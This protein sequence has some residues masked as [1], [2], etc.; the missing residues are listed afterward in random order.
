MEYDH[1][2]RLLLTLAALAALCTPASP[3]GSVVGPGQPLLCGQQIPT[4][5]QIGVSGATRIVQGVLGKTIIICGWHVTNSAAAGTFQLT[6]GTGSNCGTGTVT[7]T[8]A[9]TV[10]S[11]APATDHI[12]YAVASIPV[13]TSGTP[14]DLCINPSVAT[15]AAIVWLAQY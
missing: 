1:M 15:I 4:Q 3:Q 5:V 9:F 7:L 14:W 6:Y 10:T 8:P 13:L 2:R 11:T 12:D